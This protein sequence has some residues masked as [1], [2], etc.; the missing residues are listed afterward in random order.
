[1][2]KRFAYL[3]NHTKF[4]IQ[5]AM[6][7]PKD[8]V[9]KIY[10]INK[11]SQEYECVGLALTDH[12]NI[13]VWPQQY[14]ACLEQDDK[15]KNI[16]P[17]FGCEIYHCV[18]INNNPNKNRFHLV[19][20]A[21]NEIGIKNLYQIT[22]HAGMN[23]ISGKIKNFPVTDMNFLKTH[24]EGIICLTACIAGIVPQCIL[25]GREDSAINFINSLRSY[26]DEVYLEV[27][28]LDIPEQLLVN[29]A[30]VRL[31]KKLGIKLVMTCDTHYIEKDDKQYHDLFKE[32]SHQKPFNTDN[33]LKT[34]EEMESYCIANNIPVEA[35]TNSAEISDMCQADIKPKDHR[36][37]LPVYPC[38]NGYTESE[39]LHQL[40][41][42]KLKDKI[43]K[44]KITDI[45]KY[46]TQ[47]CY[48]LDVICNA[49]FAGYF[50]I[51]WD[52]FDWCR[53][54]DILMG[55]GRGSAAGSLISYVLDITKVDPIKNGFYF[56][57]FI[58]PERLSFP[59]IDSDI[60]RDRRS[61]GIQYLL[62]KYGKQNVSQIV[63]FGEYKVKNT[64][65]A[66]LSKYG[67]PIG[68]ANKITKS[69]PD[70]LDGKA[71]T[72]DLLEDRHNNP[73]NYSSWDNDDLKSLDK[74]W[75][76]LDDTFQKYPQVYHALKHVSGCYSNTGIHA[77]GVVVCKYPINEHGQIM[78]GSDTAVLPVLQFEMNDLD[79]YGFLKI[80]VLGLKT[81]DT[82]KYTMDLVNLDYDW[83][84]SEDYD[85]PNV[86]RML[87]NG[88]TTDVFQMSKYSPTKMIKDFNVVN[89]DGL[90]AVNAGNRPGPLEKDKTSGK[91]MVDLYIEHV[92]TS[93]PEDWGN[94]DVNEILSKTYGC[95]WYQENCIMLGRVMAGYSMGGADARIR[96]IL[97]KKLVK[98]IPEI[99]NEFIYGKK[100]KFDDDH[101]VIGIS[102]E[103]SEYC[104]GSLKRGYSLELSNKIFDNMAAFA[105][106]SFNRS[107]SF[108]YGVLAYKTA[109]LSYYYP[110]EF[111]IA[112]CTINEKEED[113][114]ATL[115]SA[116]KRK[117][118][119]L[120]PD[121]N[122]SQVNFSNDNGA[123]RYGLK[124]IKGIGARVVNFLD[125]Y[126]SI[127]SVQFK[128][129]DD[130]YYRI[131]D[132]NDNIINMLINDIQQQ[133]GKSSPN[134]LK[135][136]VEIA[137]ILSGCFDFNEPNRYKLVNHYI[138]DIR[139]ENLSKIKIMGEDVNF[140]LDEKKF[141]NKSK[142][143]LEKF[144]MGAYISE[145]PLDKFPYID[146][147]S[148]NNNEK[149]RIG[150]IVTEINKKKTKTGKDY[151]NIKF[152]AKDDIE[153]ATNIFN[154]EKVKSLSVDLKKGQIIVITGNYS[155]IYHNI[156]A[157]DLKI[158]L[159]KEQLLK[160]QNNNNDQQKVIVQDDNKAPDFTVP[161]EQFSDI[162]NMP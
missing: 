156:N 149:V 35:V 52:W 114:I 87:R 103:D 62:S 145:H 43:V 3:H 73:D 91:S 116:R 110:V 20:L 113:I 90:C 146:L 25:N 88:E 37:L 121:I 92:K 152:K 78:Q 118:K 129:F 29:D 127:N 48:E 125:Q 55:P 12:G 107:H 86:Y 65:K 111:A 154:E 31:S 101:N 138:K 155:S 122:K 135:K 32:I 112:N 76:I 33:Y 49:G 64:I 80:D 134:P 14:S 96:K 161:K 63:T 109:W 18:N 15:N 68:D 115:A 53:K 160:R 23:V 81:L 66:V 41:F 71:V 84:D 148:L 159:D 83:Y 28:P 79:F 13:S 120:P 162:F 102:E 11:N 5:D 26:F 46:I 42:T 8:Y 99:R 24:G 56:E 141:N 142:L 117:I 1:M 58:S 45:K 44:K 51:L 158:M 19:L 54:N 89:I 106:Y 147:D 59:D 16:H 36:D 72:F 82:I 40:V 77:G 126:K 10:T 97:G 98:K 100:S 70:M 139:K 34:P 61:E 143:A 67:C 151:L 57:R 124:A 7:G 2:K 131:H 69:L 144:Y 105:K 93:T 9:N 22:S 60:P 75:E 17:I 30:F 95:I 128:D 38:P 21:K 94:E 130:F 136:D 4:S 133:T 47:A 140:P 119:I 153:R 27:Q 137:L 132:T 74:A 50:L 85:D 150:G 104:E 123:I 6:P 157:T 108:C 39:Y